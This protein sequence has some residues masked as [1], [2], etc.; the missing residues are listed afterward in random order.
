MR[1]IATRPDA[2]ANAL[3]AAR[4]VRVGDRTSYRFHPQQVG[5]PITIDLFVEGVDHTI[6]EG[7]VREAGYHLA[8]VNTFTPWIWGT[9]E[10]DVDAFWG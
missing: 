5:S 4:G 2:S 3:T 9:S 6:T 7:T 8:P 1:G 10:W